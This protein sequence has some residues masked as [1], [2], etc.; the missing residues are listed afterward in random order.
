[1][2]QHL[3]AAIQALDEGRDIDSEMISKTSGPDP[4]IRKMPCS[5]ARNA[6]WEATPI[7]MLC[8]CPT[9]PEPAFERRVR[10]CCF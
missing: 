1:M 5:V 4:V 3:E 8:P 9:A 2:L 7:I 6:Q 10:V